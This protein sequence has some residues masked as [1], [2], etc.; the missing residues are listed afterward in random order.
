M[1][2]LGRYSIGTGDRFGHEG[3]AQIEAVRKARAAGVEVAIVWNKSNRE[4]TII[5][6]Q[7]SDT[8]QA[9]Q[10][11]IVASG[12]DGEWHV[13]ADHIGLATVDR[14]IDSSDFFTIDVADYIGQAADPSAVG[15]FVERHGDLCGQLAIP[16]LPRPLALDRAALARAAGTYLYAAKEAARIY[17]HIE[18]SKGAGGFIAEV[19]MDE[20]AQPQTPTELLVILAALAD[21]GVAIQTVAPKFSGRF[22]KG[23]DYVGDVSGFMAEFEAD[24]CVASWAARAFGLPENLKLSIHSGSDKFSLYQGIGRI[25]RAHGAGVHLK[26]AGTNWLEEIVGL[27]EGGGE[28]LAIAKDL[29]RQAL[30]RFDELTAPY[31]T[32]IDIDRARLPSAAEV[33]AWPSERF[34]AALRHVQ[35]NPAY[36]RNFRQLLHVAFKLAAEM[37]ARYTDALEHYREPIARNVTAN[38]WER[39]IT[40]LFLA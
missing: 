1:K 20:T 27:A 38:L 7:P 26:T 12:W 21:E 5:G 36:D 23:V 17:H 39:H 29:Y 11:A 30:P 35:A 6:T 16:G 34:A 22:N 2:R 19:S 8:A 18:Q 4:H 13:D 25:I 31:A 37:G 15:S 33:D 3:V 24:V 40:P 28:G 14:F 9:A 10:A 32:V